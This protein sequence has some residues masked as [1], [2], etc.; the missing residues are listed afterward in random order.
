[1]VDEFL[2]ERREGASDE[3]QI[4]P[5]ADQIGFNRETRED[6]LNPRHPRSFSVI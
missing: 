1:M 2:T 5:R 4:M 6:L 3:G